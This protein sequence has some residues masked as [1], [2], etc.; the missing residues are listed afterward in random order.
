MAHSL[1]VNLSILSVQPT[2]LTTYAQNVFPHLQPLQP[3]MLACQEMA[4]FETYL[5]PDGMTSDQG[6]RGHL[7]RLRWTQLQLPRIYR[8]LQS[9]LIFS[10]VPEAPLW[11][12]CRSVVMVH[13]L[14][15]L[16]MRFPWRSPLALYHRFYVPRVLRQAQHIICNSEATAQDIGHYHRIPRSKITPIPLAYDAAHFRWLDL[17]THNYFLYLGRMDPYKN[18]HRLIAAYAPVAAQAD[19]ELWIVGPIDPRYTPALMQQVTELGLSDRVQFLNYLPYA[20]L[21]TVIN[22]AIALVFPS[23]Y[24]GF[25]LP[26]LEAMACGTPVIASNQSA[27]PEVTGDAALLVDPYQTAALTSAMQ[28][29]LAEPRLRSHLHQAS[30]DRASQFSWAK[31]GQQ[32]AAILQSWL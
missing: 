22:Q 13:D 15:P 16:R 11:A 1:L 20:Q 18:V 17:P 7:R 26:V 27:I 19:V 32:T 28:Q 8:S 31:T 21:P 24:E 30:L 6:S 25:G 2:G 5:V 10:P 3:T 12:G 29:I 14:I 23:L 4:G 9:R